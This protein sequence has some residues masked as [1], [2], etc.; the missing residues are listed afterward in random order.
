MLF[1]PGVERQTLIC[2][3]GLLVSHVVLVWRQWAHRPSCQHTPEQRR[4]ARLVLGCQR[5]ARLAAAGQV[6]RWRVGVRAG[7]RVRARVW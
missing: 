4:R 6:R 7:R 5:W 3:C 2:G 1:E